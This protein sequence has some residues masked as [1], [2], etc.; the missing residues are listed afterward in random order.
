MFNGIARGKDDKQNN[1]LTN[2]TFWPLPTV[3]THR[4]MRF[5]L[6]SPPIKSTFVYF[7][8]PRS[9]KQCC[10][11]AREAPQVVN[12]SKA[13]SPASHNSK[14]WTIVTLLDV[15]PSHKMNDCS[16]RVSLSMNYVTPSPT[17]LTLQHQTSLIV[18]TD[19]VW[20][21]AYLRQI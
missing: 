19:I 10:N 17:P 14:K 16:V 20:E 4:R 1:V 21:T 7:N 2:H 6:D 5:K 11:K 18:E 3:F 9:V 8:I 12:N 13:F 15:I